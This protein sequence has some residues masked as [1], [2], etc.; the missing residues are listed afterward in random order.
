VPRIRIPPAVAWHSGRPN[1]R[2]CQSR[3]DLFSCRSI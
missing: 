1:L 3:I 2:S